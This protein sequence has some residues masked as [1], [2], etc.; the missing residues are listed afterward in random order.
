[1]KAHTKLVLAS[2]SLLLVAGFV[3]ALEQDESKLT[4]VVAKADESGSSE[5]NELV[6]LCAE[7]EEKKFEIEWSRYVV[8]NELKGKELQKTINWVSDE[9]ASQRKISEHDKTGHK[10]DEAW[11]KERQKLMNEYARRAQML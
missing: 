3:V 6:A 2:L 5:L 7:E 1:M 9:A 4:P 10:D 8:K 11:K